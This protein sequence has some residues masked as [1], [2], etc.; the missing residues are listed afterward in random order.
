MK[1]LLNKELR[2][3]ASPLSFIFLSG[4]LMTMLPGYPILM[5][6][7]FICFGVFHSFQH[8]REMNDTLYTVLLPVKKSDFVGVKYLF[9]VLIQGAGFLL[10][11]ALTALRLTALCAAPPYLNNAMMN[12]TPAYLAYVLLVFTAFN[13]FF[14][15]GFFR[16]G[17]KLG[18]PFLAFGIA[19]LLIIAT[20]E[21]LHHLPGLHFLNVPSGERI[22]VQLGILAAAA[23]IYAA[24]TALSYKKS[25]KRFEKIDL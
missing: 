11:A 15:G 12:A 20:G 2:L 19:A 22:P 6:S 4:A 18:L 23:L 5:G 1:S 14:V 10:C 7:F 3:A 24:G 8:A 9:T 25:E 13:V 16:T 21:T 17:Y